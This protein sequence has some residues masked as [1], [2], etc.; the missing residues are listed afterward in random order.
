MVYYDGYIPDSGETTSGSGSND[1]GSTNDDGDSGGDSTI[2]YGGGG[3]GSSDRQT[4]D[5][6]VSDDAT[7][8]SESGMPGGGD[9]VTDIVSPDPNEGS[10]GD[11]VTYDDEGNIGVDES[12]LDDDESVEETYEEAADVLSDDT[13]NED[14]GDDSSGIDA[15]KALAGVAV[16]GGA[17]YVGGS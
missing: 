15:K 7:E 8:D 4:Y 14:G 9:P 5:D 2:D 16:L 13:N 12:K 11:A 1:S 17:I 3:S 6:I 10:D